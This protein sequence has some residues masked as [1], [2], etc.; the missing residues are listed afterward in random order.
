MPAFDSSAIIHGWDNYPIA[1]FPPL[2]DWLA[3][4]VNAEH[5]KLS[6]VAFDE[7]RNVSPDCADWLKD[8]NLHQ[9]P[10]GNRELQEALRIKTM[11]GIVQ[12]Q[13]HPNGVG[14]NDIIIISTARLVGMDLVSN[15]DQPTA[16]QNMKKYKIPTVCRL[17]AV[18]VPCANF[19]EYLKQSGRVFR[20]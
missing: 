5:I 3:A 1:Q 7:V 9:W 15:E 17:P 4:E 18:N 8:N 14:E 16:P 19:L 13:F 10:V 20:R 6:A 12:D 2:W 11:L